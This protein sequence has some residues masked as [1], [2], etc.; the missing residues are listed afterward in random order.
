MP[1]LH[2]IGLSVEEAR[3]FS[4]RVSGAFEAE[5]RFRP[6]QVWVL[7]YEVTAF[8]NGDEVV[9]APIVRLSWLEQPRS[10]F[11]RAA[12]IITRILRDELGKTGTI[13]VELHEKS[14]DATLDGELFSDWAARLGHGRRT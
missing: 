11:V 9:P 13:Q 8:R 4:R 10:R 2:V 7:R 6:D 12:A 14:D 5:L 3:D 1:N